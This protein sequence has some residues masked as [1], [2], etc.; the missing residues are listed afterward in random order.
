[1][2][3]DEIAEVVAGQ[4][5]VVVELAVLA[6]GRGPGFPAVGLVEDVGVFLAVQRGFG[7]F[8]LLQ[9]VEV[10]QEE[11]PGGLLGVV[12]LGGA[13]GLFPEDVV[14]V[15]EGLFKHGYLLLFELKNKRL[16]FHPHNL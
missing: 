1:M 14:D 9:A 15:F 11:E 12:E 13:A 2:L 10:F 4:G 6:L 16:A 8:V 3:V 7:G 5:G